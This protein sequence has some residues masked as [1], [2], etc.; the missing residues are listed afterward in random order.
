RAP[1]AARAAAIAASAPPTTPDCERI[2]ACALPPP[3]R[4]LAGR[5]FSESSPGQP[6]HYA[7]ILDSG[8]DA[9]LARVN[10]IRSA[11]TAIDLQ[12]YIFDEDAAGRLVLDE[13]P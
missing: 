13:L 12:T 9:M 1:E 2:D 4:E 5:A 3:L 8:T 7:V 10:L 11:T 6:R